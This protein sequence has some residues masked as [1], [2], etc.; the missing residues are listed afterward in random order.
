[1]T[2]APQ[3]CVTFLCHDGN[4]NVVLGKRGASARDEQGCW[5]IGAGAVAFGETP[6]ETVIREIREEYGV[7]VPPEVMAFLG[8][9]TALREEPGGASHWLVLDFVVRIPDRLHGEVRN[10]EPEKLDAVGWFRPEKLP[11]PMH[12]QWPSLLTKNETLLIERGA[13]TPLGRC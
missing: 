12:S 10:A 4:G 11:S 7:E 2:G 8:Y 5:D 3:V 13:W 6:E 1:M 9:R